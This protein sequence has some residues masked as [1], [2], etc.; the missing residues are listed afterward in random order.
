[1]TALRKSSPF[2]DPEMIRALTNPSDGITGRVSW[3][4]GRVSEIAIQNGSEIIDAAILGLVSRVGQVV[5][6]DL[7][8]GETS[9]W[10]ALTCSRRVSSA[11]GPAKTAPGNGAIGTS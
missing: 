8:V 1:M 3:L 10:M 6:D 9:R 7:P 4:Q 11:V 5:L 2:G